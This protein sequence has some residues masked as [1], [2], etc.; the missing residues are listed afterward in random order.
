MLFVRDKIR[1]GVLIIFGIVFKG[2]NIRVELL[3]LWSLF[4]FA[5]H[6]H[7][8]ELMMEGI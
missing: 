4:T 1:R 3:G 7:L 8:P 2:K 6:L 5:A